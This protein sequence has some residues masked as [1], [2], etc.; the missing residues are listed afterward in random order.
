MALRCDGF[1]WPVFRAVIQSF[2][3]SGLGHVGYRSKM[4]PKGVGPRDFGKPFPFTGCFEMFW[5]RSLWFRVYQSGF[6]WGWSI[7]FFECCFGSLQ[8]CIGFAD[9]FSQAWQSGSQRQNVPKWSEGCFT[10]PYSCQ[11]NMNPQKNLASNAGR[12]EPPVLFDEATSE[13]SVN[14]SAQDYKLQHT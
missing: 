6:C 7:Q 13:G 14:K 8:A 12:S 10:T 4:K 5:P 3:Q 2:E 11:N 9:D 1:T